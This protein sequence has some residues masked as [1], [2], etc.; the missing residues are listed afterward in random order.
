MR[1][2]AILCCSWWALTNSWLTIAV[3]RADTA[4]GTSRTEV[5][6]DTEI[7]PLLTRHGCN[8]GSC[9]G[10]A[11]GRGGFKLSLLGSDAA[12]DFDTIVHAL[13]GRRVNRFRSDRSLLLLKP[14]EQVGHEGGLIFEQDSTAF[15]KLQAWIDQGARRIRARELVA[16]RTQPDNV[17]L[18][19]PGDSIPLSILATFQGSVTNE[20]DVTDWTVLTPGDAEAVTVD[21]E[22]HR[23]T[24]HRPGVQVVIARF[25]DRVLPIRLTVPMSANV[26]SAN[27][28]QG[29]AEPS[30]APVNPIDRFVD[31][32]L[33]Q[34]R[35]PASPQADD[36]AFLRRVTL[37]LCG[38]LPTLAEI[39]SFVCDPQPDQSL[40]EKGADPL[41]RGQKTNEIDS[42]PKGQTPFRIGSKRAEKISELINSREFAE[43]WALKWANILMIHAGQLQAEGAEAYHRWL[44]D[45]IHRDTPLREIA[46]Q[47]I[48]SVGDGFEVG[49]ANFSRFGS[50]PGDLAEHVTRSLM[51]VRLQ[52]ANCHNH[53]LDHWTQDDYHG[54]SAVF[55]KL[56]RGRVVS[57]TDRGEVT[58]PV[59]RQAAV[60][61]IPGERFL[62]PT[63][64]GRQ[65]IADWLTNT[66]NP[67][68]ARVTVNRLWR[69]LM[70]RGLV[71]P[72]DDLRATNPATHPGLLDW[73][74]EDFSEHGFRMKSTIAKICNSRAYQRQSEPVSGNETDTQFYSHKLARA[75]EAEVIADAIGDVTGIGLTIDGVAASRAVT[76]TNN[77]AESRELD[78]LGR[79]DRSSDCSSASAPAES[80]TR[81][82]HL[83][84]GPLLQDRVASDD[85]TLARWLQQSDD[86]RWVLDQLF[87]LTLTRPHASASPVW[88]KEWKHAATWD[89]GQR[90]A[91]FEDVFWGIL[92]SQAFVTNH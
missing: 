3:V 83:I 24:V 6:F 75:L 85:G 16:L 11:I 64:N 59:T 50:S 82:L 2:L 42:P 71:E 74:A 84:N 69:E 53:P 27:D 43:Y 51:G 78:L 89:S 22:A 73:L 76:V 32:Q 52:C 37:D 90:R 35:I 45:Q 17:V 70:G 60:P 4:A 33:R 92:A 15:E 36:H 61:R 55:A 81:A 40:S 13:E 30:G 65:A 28:A 62:Q 63:E 67:Y 80:L 72:V 26:P 66:Q 77:L 58:H 7:M 38:R 46:Q 31:E 29:L 87:L 68:L 79:C 1:S 20:V 57:V 10:A 18:D 19:Q 47:L 23:L 88:R 34:L 5:D 86:D 56:S 44:A 14:S 91:F 39:E 8:A 49:P 54:L 41:R 25:M 12:V 48:M 9:H 21:L